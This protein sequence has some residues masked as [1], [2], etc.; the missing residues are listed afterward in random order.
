MDINIQDKI[1]KI[2]IN[3][4]DIRYAPIE[5]KLWFVI[6]DICRIVGANLANIYTRISDSL[7][8]RKIKIKKQFVRVTNYKGVEE[9]LSYSRSDRVGEILDSLVKI[10]KQYNK[11]FKD[12]LIGKK[13]LFNKCY[14]CGLDGVWHDKPLD[15]VLVNNDCLFLICP[16]CYSQ[17][18]RIVF[19]E[20]CQECDRNVPIGHKLC[21]KCQWKNKTKPTKER[22]KRD[23]I[24]HGIEGVEKKYGVDKTVVISWMNE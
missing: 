9:I 24:K 12:K 16:N 7:D 11:E 23:L 18:K 5:G 20:I 19:I 1:R 8:I 6:T 15:L 14:T 3:S 22:L 2:E 13:F 10:I 21:L 17:T 4:T